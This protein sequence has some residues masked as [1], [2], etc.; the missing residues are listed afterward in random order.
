MA[1]K[2]SPKKTAPKSK[3]A[4]EVGARVQVLAGDYANARGVVKDSGSKSTRAFLDAEVHTGAA[5]EF[6][7]A[8]LTA[9]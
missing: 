9:V 5:V 3:P 8:N 2:S 4:F 7:N 1:K 6:Q